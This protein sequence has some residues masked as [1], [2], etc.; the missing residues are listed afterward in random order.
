[1]FIHIRK[2]FESSISLLLVIVSF[3]AAQAIS[4]QHHLTKDYLP[5]TI[6]CSNPNH[7]VK[8]T[9]RLEYDWAKRITR[10]TS[11]VGGHTGKENRFDTRIFYNEDGQ[12]A[13]LIET[14]I[15]DSSFPRQE[16]RFEY[17]GVFLEKIR[18][19]QGEGE[20]SVG[21]QYSAPTNTYNIDYKGTWQ[22]FVF[23]GDDVLA[24]RIKGYEVFAVHSDKEVKPGVLYYVR[25]RLPLSIVSQTMGGS[26]LAWYVLGNYQVDLLVYNDQNIFITTKRD[27]YGRIAQLDFSTDELGTYQTTTIDYK[28]LK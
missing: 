27:E 5:G 2:T 26:Q 19:D 3:L 10:I 16:Y 23:E 13:T 6:V 14:P 8:D 25:D 22:N 20:E 21:V 15:G 18:F 9:I 24:H 7:N 12:M 17:D 1:M 4:A 28:P 11:K